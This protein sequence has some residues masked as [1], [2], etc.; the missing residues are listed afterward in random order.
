[1]ADRG[2][3]R[4]PPRASRSWWPGAARLGGVSS[5]GVPAPPVDLADVLA[6][7]RGAFL[8]LAA[9][10]ALGAPVEFLTAAEIRAERGRQT[11]MTGGGWLRLAPGRFTDDT[12][13]ARCVARAIDRRGGFDL[14]AVADELAAWLR[15]N[16]ID[17]G[18]TVRKGLRAYLVHG[19]LESP[20]NAWDAGNGAAM[21]LL[22]VA[23]CTLGDE[24]LL[25]RCLL[26]Q[27]H[28]THHHPLSD[29]GC[30]TLGRMLQLA[31]L[32]R[33][34][35]RLRR[36]A[37]ALVERHPAF[38]FDPYRGLASGYV[39]DT[40]QTV[41]HHFFR[42]RGLEECLVEVVN[43]GG[44]ADTT[45]AIAGAL[46]GAFYAGAEEL[47]RRWIRRMDPAALEELGRLAE[48]MVALSPLA[49][50]TAPLG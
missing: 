44:D 47:P 38:R 21:R 49:R 23:L 24:E 36:E 34:K 5:P 45:G 32:G 16:P 41:F 42:T 6:R 17:V 29:A 12:E 20:F 13:M 25:D 27:G 31:V 19:Q 7:A 18:N 11:E 9:G 37:D 43:Q 26:A 22:P 1:M 48:R 39:V 15:T 40:L 3:Y 33:S 28:L 8:G 50:G 30:A 46:A 4:R 14:R 35:A 10:D 2:Y